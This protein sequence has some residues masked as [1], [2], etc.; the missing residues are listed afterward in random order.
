MDTVSNLTE[1]EYQFAEY[2]ASGFDTH[3]IA[4]KLFIAYN[5][6]RC[7]KNNIAK[8]LGTKNAVQVCLAMFRNDPDKFLNGLGLLL[9]LII[10]SN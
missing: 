5:T 6:A 4:D 10:L 8:K 2:W 1:R 9:A 3:E 7:Y